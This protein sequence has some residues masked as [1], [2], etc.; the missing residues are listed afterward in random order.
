M[1][2]DGNCRKLC[3]GCP[4]YEKCKEL[5]RQIQAKWSRDHE[6][7]LKA[8]A[9]EMRPMPVNLKSPERKMWE[10]AIKG[11]VKKKHLKKSLEGF[12]G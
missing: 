11:T 4:D 8:H 5:N 10:E 12:K 7:W 2:N 9:S 3:K 6:E 1:F